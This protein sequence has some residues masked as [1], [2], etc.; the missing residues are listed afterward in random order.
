MIIPSHEPA[1]KLAEPA[2]SELPKVEIPVALCEL[3]MGEAGYWWRVICCP[4]CGRQHFHGAGRKGGNPRGYLSH[5]VGHCRLN[6]DVAFLGYLLVE[7]DTRDTDV[8]LGG[9]AE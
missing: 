2:G 3:V 5:R 1:R 4:S 8:K 9:A 7:R 6:T